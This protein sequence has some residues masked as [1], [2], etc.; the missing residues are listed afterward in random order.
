MVTVDSL[1]GRESEM[2]TVVGLIDG[3]RD[4][5]GALV[6]S[7]EPGIGKSALLAVAV[8]RAEDLGMRVLRATG[9]QS[10]AQLAFSGLHQL[11]KPLLPGIDR[12]PTPQRDAIGAAL[13]MTDGAAPDLFLIGLA[14]LN[15]I[16]NAAS[17][18]PVLVIAEDAH[19]LD[20]SS[21]DVLAFVARRLESEPVAIL[22]AIRDGFESSI[23]SVGLPSLYIGRL[24][25]AAAAALLDAKAPPD[26]ETS[27]R[28]ALSYATRCSRAS[29][30]TIPSSGADHARPDTSWLASVTRPS[31]DVPATLARGDLCR[32]AGP[33]AVI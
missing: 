28:P 12:L 1:F 8:A 25:V 10:E 26:L 22:A 9:V 29:L 21:S 19:W 2:E 7:G 33:S 32:R 20:H 6:V 14:V 30:S 18:K 13:G 5:G 24:D 15:L 27:V 3:V 31:I 11:V 16:A 23:G 4:C 17:E